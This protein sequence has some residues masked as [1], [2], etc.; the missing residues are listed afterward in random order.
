[1]LV[2]TALYTAAALC[3]LGTVGLLQGEL[4]R[5]HGQLNQSL[6]IY[7]SLADDRSTAECLCALGGHAAAVDRPE[8]A[9]RLWG[10]A[11]RLRGDSPLEYAEPAIEARFAPTV[12]RALGTKRYAALRADGRHGFDRSVLE[13]VP[14]L[15]GAQIAE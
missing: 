13:G 3:M 8:D 2:E 4:A 9:A 11:D 15:G 7:T 1:M 10:A 5:S 12:R 6:A 14:T